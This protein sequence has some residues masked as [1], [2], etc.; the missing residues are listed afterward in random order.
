[1]NRGGAVSPTLNVNLT[2]FVIPCKQIWALF[3]DLQCCKYCSF[4]SDFSSDFQSSMIMF[5]NVIIVSLNLFYRNDIQWHVTLNI[6]LS[7]AN[8]AFLFFKLSTWMQYY[9][10]AITSRKHGKKK[11]Q[12]FSHCNSFDHL[13][14]QSLNDYTI[15]FFSFCDWKIK[16]FGACDTPLK[17]YFQ[18]L[19]NNMLRAPKY[20]KFSW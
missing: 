20:L 17:I 7:V 16:C 19:S 11:L 12:L 15:L 13:D 14:L 1:M 9:S 8:M 3:I 2:L 6:I 5:V 10:L 18:N 4:L